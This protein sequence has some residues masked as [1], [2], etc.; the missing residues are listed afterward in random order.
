VLSAYQQGDSAGIAG[1]SSGHRLRHQPGQ[2]PEG[3]SAARRLATYSNWSLRTRLQP[4]PEILEGRPPLG[5]GSYGRLLRAWSFGSGG[6][7]AHCCPR[8]RWV[9]SRASGELHPLWR[10]A[11]RR[12]GD[13]DRR[14]V[15]SKVAGRVLAPVRL[16]A[17]CGTVR[18]GIPPSHGSVRNGAA[19]TRA[20]VHQC[21]DHR[22]VRAPGRPQRQHRRDD[23]ACHRL[24]GGRV[25]LS[26][27]LGFLAQVV[28]HL[29]PFVAAVL[30]GVVLLGEFT[31]AALVRNTLENLVL[32]R[33][34]Q[35]IRGYYRTWSP[36]PT[37][38]S[39]K[40]P[41]RSGPA[42]RWPRWGCGPGPRGCCS[43]EPA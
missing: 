10:G 14:V 1:R 9:K 8:I 40:L 34:M 23:R 24:H 39:A 37:S 17:R 31:F 43:P 15:Q 30:P 32:L 18:Q 26:D 29:D 7:P 41:R 6:A 33:Q 19:S 4:A 11:V 27:R 36:R 25:Q 13:L 2:R 35:R 28:T 38:S 21:P 12:V 5:R 42:P 20:G 22:A 3:A 16:L